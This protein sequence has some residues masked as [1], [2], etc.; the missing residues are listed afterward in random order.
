MRMHHTFRI[1]LAM[2]AGAVIAGCANGVESPAASSSAAPSASVAPSPAPSP[3][4]ATTAPAATPSS[5]P[6]DPGGEKPL[7]TITLTEKPPKEPTDQ[8][9]NTGWVA[10][11]VT[12]GGKGPCYGLVA[13]DGQKYALYSTTGVELAQGA[14]V[15]VK[16]ETTMLRIYCGPGALMAMT[17]AELIK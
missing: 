17:E 8:K 3:T 7:P 12:R 9:P 13:D 16:L 10:G 4:G 2:A 6:A 14:R 15:K 1:G 11:M 5:S